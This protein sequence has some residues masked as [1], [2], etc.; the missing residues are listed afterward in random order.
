MVNLRRPLINVVDRE[1]TRNAGPGARQSHDPIALIFFQTGQP[2]P[3]QA[4][5]VE[6]LAPFPGPAGFLE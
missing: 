3:V 2:M 5:L 1:R 4:A 6:P